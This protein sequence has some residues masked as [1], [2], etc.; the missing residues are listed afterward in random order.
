LTPRRILLLLPAALAACTV[1]PDYARPDVPAPEAWREG[2]KDSTSLADTPW[3]DLF[4]DKALVGMIRGA[5]EANPDVLIAMERIHEAR[6]RAGFVRADLYPRVDAGLA[7]GTARRSTEILVS[8]NNLERDPKF[9]D[10]EIHGALSW[11]LDLWGRIRRGVE[12]G[13]AQLLA[14]EE[15]RRAVVVAV[16]AEVA[17]AYLELR[18]LDARTEYARGTVVSRRE[19]VDLAR[20]RFEGGVTSEL[21]FRQAEAELA[22][23][24]SVLSDLERQGRQ[25]ENE[26]SILLGKNPGERP[27][28]ASIEMMPAPPAVPAGIPAKILE[29]RPDIR[30]AEQALVS[31]N[32]RIGEAK[33]LM[34]PRV[35]LT[36]AGGYQST[37]VSNFITSSGSFW[38]LI[39]GVMAPIWDWGKNKARVEENEARARAAVIQY[40][41]S[42]RQAFREVEDA[43]VAIRKAGE[44]RA[45]LDARVQAQRVVLGLAEVRYRG[46]VSPYLEVLDAQRALFD[47]ELERTI[48]VREQLTAVVR[49]YRA[50]G[51][52]WSA[53]EAA[54][55][56][57]TGN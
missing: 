31:A 27:R 30:A 46:G 1:G 57:A 23:T 40:Q 17:R 50:L 37:D 55:Q 54:S 49:L 29:R 18:D 56:P 16:V 21:D 38:S 53:E 2:L 9:Q 48:V 19:Y 26:L 44:R 33:A 5:L 11:E 20:L 3:W 32:A 10:Y 4:K 42:I 35:A 12:A 52:G 34:Y 51:G 47:S 36:V 8:P 39:G 14:A 25:K 15:G 28:G 7:A 43:L 13:E 41:A 45:A 6:A 24:Q 22:R